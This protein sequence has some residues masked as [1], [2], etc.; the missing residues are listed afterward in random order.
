M[1]I[2]L[3]DEPYIDVAM[4]YASSDGEAS[5]VLLQDAVYATQTGRVRGKAFALDLDVMRRGL[6][7][8]IPPS[9]T[10]IG[11]P[12][13]VQMMERDRVVNFL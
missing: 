9:V 6:A 12:E 2:Y 11:Y 3:V 4:A 5:L 13:L 7:G 8:R 10:V 1:T